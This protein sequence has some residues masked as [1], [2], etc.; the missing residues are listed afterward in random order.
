MEHDELVTAIGQLGTNAIKMLLAP[1]TMNGPVNLRVVLAFAD[2]KGRSEITT[3]ADDLV[4]LGLL[5]SNDG[6]IELTQD[7]RAA[8]TIVKRS[9]LEVI[10]AQYAAIHADGASSNDVEQFLDELLV[11]Y[12]QPT[13][14]FAA[15]APTA[16]GDPDF[17]VHT[18]NP[19]KPGKP[20]PFGR[21]APEGECARC[22]ELRAG[23]P[24]REAP[25]A[26]RNSSRD[27]NGGYP[28]DAEH[29]RHFRPGGPH[30][31]GQCG[32][33]CTFGQW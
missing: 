14:L 15:K 2:D 29:E 16:T 12:G 32:P 7:G 13:V 4:E 8:A 21:R 1:A 6:E 31:T 3:A 18:C 11:A 20:R 30:A 27:H 25:P 5:T 26:I 24:P 9:P 19:S 10:R 22:D 28:T 23:A 33:V 17:K